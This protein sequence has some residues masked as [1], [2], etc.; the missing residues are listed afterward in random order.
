MITQ[1]KIIYFKKTFQNVL[2]MLITKC[3]LFF[4]FVEVWIFRNMIEL[5]R[6]NI[7]IF[8]RTKMTFF[9]YDFISQIESNMLHDL[10]FDAQYSLTLNVWISKQEQSFLTIIAYYITKAW[11]YKK[12][13][14]RFKSLLYQHID[15]EMINVVLKLLRQYFINS[16]LL[17]ITSDNVRFN[18]TL[19]THFDALLR[20]HCNFI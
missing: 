19:R 1:S 14:L 2:K 7:I 17:I 12:A 11:L 9:C 3:N 4:R 20:E 10:F 13:F 15:W 5:L 8:D 16:R 18:E 6:S